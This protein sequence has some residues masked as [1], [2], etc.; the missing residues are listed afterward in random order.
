[1]LQHAALEIPPQEADRCAAFWE[2]LGFSRVDPPESL[3]GRTTW[4]QRDGTQIHLLHADD[5]VA[6][7]QGHAAV[8][9]E[10]YE[11][12]LDRLRDHGFEPEP[13]TEHWG[14][15]RAFVEDPA[16]HRVEVM[17][18]PPPP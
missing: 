2:L 8:V 18:A 17:A 5:P 1:M 3:Q 11:A 14:A 7:P 15:P 9:V 12:A 10:D 16:G 13:R 6:P 4:V